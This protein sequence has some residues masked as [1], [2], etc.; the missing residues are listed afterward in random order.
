MR[1]IT[2]YIKSDYYRF[3]GEKNPSMFKVLKK[4]FFGRETGFRYQFW[5]RMASD[6]RRLFS[7][8]MHRRLSIKYGVYI[9]A[10]T[11]IGYGLCI[12]HCVGIVINGGTIIG[13]N[14]NIGQFLTIGTNHKTPAKIGDNVY[15]GPN[16]CI[17]EDVII[18]ND[19]TIGAGAVVT[20]DV[21]SNV[22]V[23]GVPAKIIGENHP[24]YINNRY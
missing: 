9:P 10:Y 8:Y 19:V 15:I 21:P 4:A 1:S 11:K 3:F 7:R 12:W 16:V 20:K 6:R 2:E 24:E 17:V 22:T 13:N 5:L 14:V 23:A 18:E